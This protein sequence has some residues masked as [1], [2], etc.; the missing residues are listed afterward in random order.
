MAELSCKYTIY[1]YLLV[2]RYL[3]RR[4]NLLLLDFMV[5]DYL[6]FLPELV[7]I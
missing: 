7:I 5:T 1:R 2:L 6:F 4:D 3:F